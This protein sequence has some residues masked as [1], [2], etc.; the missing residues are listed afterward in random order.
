MLWGE[1]KLSPPSRISP[2]PHPLNFA[3]SGSVVEW[4]HASRKTIELYGR[5][6]ESHLRAV[7][8]W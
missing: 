2:P 5:G 6:G 7:S 3:S 1:L 4:G 8:R